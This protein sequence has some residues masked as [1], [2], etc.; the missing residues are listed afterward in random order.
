MNWR[1][2]KAGLLVAMFTAA[3][4]GALV[5]IV[6]P[7][8]IWSPKLWILFLVFGLKG[9]ALYLKQHPVHEVVEEVSLK[10]TT[11]VK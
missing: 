1:K 6:E 10:V 3:V 7:D 4:D 9:G 8:L 5:T 2:W 11:D